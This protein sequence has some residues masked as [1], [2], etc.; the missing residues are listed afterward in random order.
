MGYHTILYIYIY[1]SGRG[2]LLAFRRVLVLNDSSNPECW[3]IQG[4]EE[5]NTVYLVLRVSCYQ[6]LAK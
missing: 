6:S 3:Y 2:Y 4:T 5:E 1:T